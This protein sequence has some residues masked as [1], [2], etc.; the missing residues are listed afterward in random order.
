MSEVKVPTSGYSK[1]CSK[2]EAIPPNGFKIES[3]IIYVRAH[4]VG[5]LG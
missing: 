1:T 3:R 5:H 2:A 4:P